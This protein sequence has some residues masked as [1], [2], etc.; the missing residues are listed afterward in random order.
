MPQLSTDDFQQFAQTLEELEVS[1]NHLEH[2]Q[3][4][5]QI[6]SWEYNIPDDMLTFSAYARDIFISEE[7]D[8]NPPLDKALAYI[9]PEDYDKT[10]A[11]VWEAA[12]KGIGFAADFRICHGNTHDIRY[13]KAQAEAIWKDD[14]PYKLVGV[15]QDCTIQHY[16]E[17]QVEAS[18][19]R[20][21]LILDHLTVGLWMKEYATEKVVYVSEGAGELLQ[22]PLYEL[23]EVPGIWDD[24]I[25]PAERKEVL[26]R[27]EILKRGETL[28]HQYRIQ[29]GDGTLKWVYDQTIPWFNEQG[30]L[31]HLFG[32]LADI[33][34]EVE[35][36]QK[37]EYLATHDA[38]TALPNQRSLY[39]KLDTLCERDASSGFALFY[40]DLDRFQLIN[41]SLGY[42]F[43]DQIL[44]RVSNRLVSVLP[45]D[46]YL[47]RISSNDFVAVIENAPSQEFLLNL[48]ERMIET[49]EMPFTIDSYELH[50][51]TS[52]GISF[53]PEDGDDKLSLIQN[54][55][56]A[57]HRAKQLGKNNYQLYS[58]SKDITSYKK[59]VLEKDMRKAIENEEFEIYFQPQIETGTGIIKGAEAL[60]R[61]HH[62]DWGLVSP[63]E[64]I[65]LAE[66]NH[67]VHKIGHW[68]IENVCR[69]LRSWKDQG[70][71]LRPIAIN[72]SPIQLMKKGLVDVVAK[73]LSH[74]DIPAKY[75]EL[76]ITEG[77]LLKSEKMVLNTLKDLRELGIKIA[78]DDFGTGFSSLIYL[79]EFNPDIIKIDKAFIQSLNAENNREAAIISSVLHLA[80][81]LDMKVIAEGVEEHSQLEFLKQNECGECQGYLFSKPVSRKTFEQMLVTGYLKPS[82]PK[83]HMPAKEE[84]RKYYRLVFPNPLLGNMTIVEIN[85]RTVNLGS[86]QVLILD[87]GL[88]GLKIMTSLKLPVH[89]NIKLNFN[90]HLM[91]ESFQLEGRLVWKNEAKGDTFYYGVEFNIS[92]QE[93][94]NLAAF[95]NKMSAL[96]RLNQQIPD[97]Y[98]IEGSPYAY[99]KNHHL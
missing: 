84:R 26:S 5:A 24:L 89:S 56:A 39:E 29:C 12:E 27:Q 15:V 25:H 90:V 41:D 22:Y 40:L 10:S 88:G 65:P 4:I 43:G 87:I 95:V 96:Q 55:H 93:K 18:K 1:K 14:K 35:M 42:T 57:L 59:F 3:Q 99:I 8:G 79:K 9:H 80:K 45:D 66:E 85:E 28:Q 23:Y 71:T 82:K 53:Y 48:S 11:A 77:T 46:A 6:G 76:E 33:T 58:M 54:A 16:L 2:A 20:I 7:S 34:H 47:A 81:G 49:I 74:Y 92:E 51:T 91:G 72:V 50:I 69:Q 68:V 67:L 83:P 78:L 21:Q 36:R 60:I 19:K 38:L 37:L 44:K 64:F 30:E 61:W 13:L 63:G 17:N 31:T 70:F 86:A 94:D 73:Q 62:A 32:M 75:L 97:T 52:I 98:F